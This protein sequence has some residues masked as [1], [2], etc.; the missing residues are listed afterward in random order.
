M[1]LKNL[2]T[3]MQVA[4]LGSFTKAGEKLGYSQ[5]TVSFQIRQLE[6]ELGVP[7]FER[8]NHTVSLTETGERLLLS[9]HK[10]HAELDSFRKG[11]EPSGQVE[12]VVRLAL[13]DSLCASLIDRVFPALHEAYPRITVDC[14]TAG[15]PDLLRMLNQNEA[16]LIYVLDRPVRN[17]HYEILKTDQVNTYFVCA[18]ENPL[19]H[20]TNVS[21]EELISQP[22]LLTEK[23]MSYRRIFDETLAEDGLEILPVFVS[24]DTN[25]LCSLAAKNC[26]IALLP[27]YACR[28]MIEEGNLCR[29]H[30][31]PVLQPVVFR[32]LLRHR[33]KWVTDAIQ[34][35]S[36]CLCRS[37]PHF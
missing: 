21:R 29:I 4:E 2:A 24:G 36:S 1:E 8:I 27:D 23:G 7:V 12:G 33:D 31:D 18:P 26:G 20:R 28:S 30:T 6:E 16:D 34:I 25:L 11:T 3:F 15:T 13:A 35:V 37:T 22:F 19:A 14:S 10:I 32:Q 17:A 5:S 9:A